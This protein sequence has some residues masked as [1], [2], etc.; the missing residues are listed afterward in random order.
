M[1]HDPLHLLAA[2]MLLNVVHPRQSFCPHSI[3]VL[4]HLLDGSMRVMNRWTLSSSIALNTHAHMHARTH[5]RTHTHT[6]THTLQAAHTAVSPVSVQ[7]WL[8]VEGQTG[9][10]LFGKV[11]KQLEVHIWAV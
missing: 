2:P 7:A 1:H 10:L 11:I 8:A 9:G 5:A 3:A 6:H 4:V